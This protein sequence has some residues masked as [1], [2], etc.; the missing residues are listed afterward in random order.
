M[1]AALKGPMILDTG[2]DVELPPCEPGI[3]F[4]NHEGVTRPRVEKRQRKLL[5]QIAGFV[6]PFLA[7]D[8]RI[9]LVTTGC[10]PFSLLEQA[11]TGWI[12]VYLKRA[13]FVFTDRRILHVPTTPKYGYR[14]SL[15]QILYADC[16]TIQVRGSR[17]IV[18]YKSGKKE[19]FNYIDRRERRKIRSLVERMGLDATPSAQPR[20]AHLCP[21]CTQPLPA[22]ADRCP[23]CHLTFKTYAEARRISILYPGGGYFYTRHPWLGIG[24]ACTEF[25]LMLLVGVN[26]WMWLGGAQHAAGDLLL[27]S[28]LLVIEKVVTILHCLHFVK[29]FIPAENTV[30]VAPIAARVAA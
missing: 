8:E 16:K 10:S 7:A 15:A 12:I 22:Q 27:F 25:A 18:V 24:D 5:G 21:S 23:T 11:M 3:I 29:E 19:V 1:E 20:R 2:R 13:M 28:L 9:W 30:R 14:H 6:R 26:L 17:L 4:T